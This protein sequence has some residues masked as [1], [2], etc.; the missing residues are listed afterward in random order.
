[1]TLS[2]LF[3]ISTPTRA[4]K[5]RCRT[6]ASIVQSTMPAAAGRGVYAALPPFKRPKDAGT[7]LDTF[8]KYLKRANMVFDTEDIEEDKKKKALLQLWGGDEMINFFEHEGKVTAEDTFAQAM[9]KIRNALK[10]QI[11]EMYPVFKLFC[12]MPQGKTPFTEWYTKVLDQAKLCNFAAYD[13]KKAAR[14]A[15]TMQTNNQKLRK[16]ALAEE[17]GFDDFVKHGIALESS[18]SQAENIEKQESVNMINRRRS[19]TRADPADARENYDDSQGRKRTDRTPKMCDF[20]GYERRKAHSK[21]KCPAK[22]KRCNV[23]KKKHHFA[24]ATVC[25]GSQPVNALEDSSGSS[26]DDEE[27]MAGRILSVNFVPVVNDQKDIEMI[28][29]EVNGTNLKMRVDSG[30]KK[31]LIP[32]KDFRKFSKTTRLYRSKVKLRPYGTKDLLK[33]KGRAKLELTT[34]SGATSDQLVYIIEGDYIEPLLG[35]EASLLGA[36]EIHPEGRRQDNDMTTPVYQIKKPST[37]P[38]SVTDIIDSHKSVFHGIG[39][40]KKA[41]INFDIDR[42]V[43]PMV[44]KERPIPFAYRPFER[45]ERK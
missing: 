35:L 31:T 43:K 26:D 16:H 14:D 12:E 2:L 23:C 19:A 7:T 8:E 30:C 34:V 5:V 15:M 11:N 22:G 20:C 27:H 9:E 1:M 39:K 17:I 10:G 33:V 25:P 4:P 41:E 6:F 38:Q 37:I 13:E 32:E 3:S 21:G 28:D 44:Q 42:N 18:S 29:M 40:F 24:H 36:L 45:T